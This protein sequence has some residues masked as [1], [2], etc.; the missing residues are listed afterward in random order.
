M[1]LFKQIALIVVFFQIMTLGGVVY[2]NF[3]SVNEQIQNRL[4]SDAQ[5]TATSL[6]LSISM[7]A[8]TPEADSRIKTMINAIFDS[9]YY[10]SIVLKDLDNKVIYEKQNPEV[11]YSVPQWFVDYVAFDTPVAKS[12]IMSGWSRFGTI[13]IYN[14]N[15][16]AYAQ[17]WDVLNSLLKWFGII[18]LSAVTA[19][20]F[21][22]RV[23]FKP[24]K[25]VQYQAEA[26][27]QNDFIENSDVPFTTELKDVT[28]AMN[29]M[30]L[31]V[32]DIFNREVEAVKKY[33]DV[34]CRDQEFDVANRHFFMSTL[35]GYLEEKDGNA[36][37]VIVMIR[38]LHVEQMKNR[39]G[40]DDFYGYFQELLK[41]LKAIGDTYSP[42]AVCARFSPATYALLL[43]GREIYKEM[44]T[45]GN[46]LLEDINGIDVFEPTV[47]I[48]MF[49]IGMTR[50]NAD[51]SIKTIMSHTDYA[52]LQAELKIENNYHLYQEKNELEDLMLR[53][54]EVW[55]KAISEAIDHNRLE[56]VSQACI[57]VGN[58][59]VYH[60]EIYTKMTTK[61]G[62]V[63]SAEFFLPI[64][65]YAGLLDDIDS[66]LFKTMIQRDGSSIALNISIDSIKNSMFVTLVQEF[67]YRSALKRKK[68][69][70]H[71][72][73]NLNSIGGEVELVADF[74]KML[75]RLGYSFGIDHFMFWPNSID[76]IGM[77][78]PAYL[79]VSVEHLANYAQEDSFH[80]MQ[81]IHNITA[82]Y[83]VDI[84]AV[85]V[86]NEEHKN[87]LNKIDIRLI[88]GRYIE[89]IKSL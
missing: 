63:L 81:S 12:E 18:F 38:F 44:Q 88:Q 48:P 42:D 13:Y 87:I 55:V 28:S 35:S 74:S 78:A 86:E 80:M 6:G 69:H 3:H 57:D 21:L 34:L 39:S 66:Y 71:F 62:D 79:K 25:K 54:R 23:V 65:K 59:T 19:L 36:F 60:Q 68:P 11:V 20:Y 58:S 5:D 26:I 43:P 30:V 47:T 84:I 83:G 14:H 16:H 77:I 70:I 37:G 49:S 76:L 56:W 46:R 73:I 32:K 15:G 52:L 17:M 50:Y 61:E 24:L 41:H 72:E 51:A 10:R 89:D 1:S 67:A 9:G 82:T 85:N 64:A 40:Y 8:E 45:I 22:L 53:G 4:F 2:Q 33:R 27:L 75:R 7:V 29:S 31:K